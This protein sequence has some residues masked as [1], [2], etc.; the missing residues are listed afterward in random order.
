MHRDDDGDDA[1]SLVSDTSPATPFTTPAQMSHP[2]PAVIPEELSTP[3]T[4]DNSH[5]L[6]PGQTSVNPRYRPTD[7]S[8]AKTSS[9]T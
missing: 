8:V 3:P 1:V 2:E 7:Q 5:T 6:Q 4:D 9:H